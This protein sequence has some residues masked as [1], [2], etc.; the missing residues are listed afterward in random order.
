MK[1]LLFFLGFFVVQLAWARQEPVWI[2]FRKEPVLVKN[3]TF[4]LLRIR[5]ERNGKSQ[6]GS[7]LSASKGN[8]P[9][10]SNDDVT[11]VFDDLLRPGF[12]PDSTRVPVIIRIREFTFT[13]KIKTDAQADGTCRLELAFD[14][15]RDGKPIQLTTYTARTIYTRSFGQTDRLEL[16]ARKALESAAQYLSNWIKVNRDKSP[17]LVK[18]IKFAYIDYSIQQASGDTVFYHPLRPLTWDDFQGEPR[19]SSR[20]A[21]SIFP[22][23]SYDGRSR[24]VNGYLLVELTFKT[25]M[26][27][28]MSWVRPG[29][30]DDYG[31][32]HEQKHFDIVKL[33]VE[34]FKQRIASDEHMDLDDYNSRVQFLYLEAY[35]DMNRWQQQYDDETQ[36][37]L[38]HA[39]QE[40]WS[41]KVASD[42]RN[43]EDLTAIMISNRQ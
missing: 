11:D 7:I 19:L 38:N 21:A 23:F 13:E 22:T 42:L 14:V 8:L 28:N 40:R 12:Q 29:N 26:V 41:Q 39:E 36:H 43:A 3:A 4:S 1:P 33:I 5:D 25:F 2:A 35:R 20:S 24:W 15:M 37:G 31:L 30:K 32:R 18:G 6:L 17:A 9:V 27:K 10:R 34:R 16:V